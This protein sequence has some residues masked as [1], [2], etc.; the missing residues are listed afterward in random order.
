[1]R[2]DLRRYVA[3]PMLADVMVEQGRK[4]TW[5]AR[6]LHIH[7]SYLSR[8]V[9]GERMVSEL[10]ARSIA[11]H[12]GVPFGLLFI[13]PDG[14]GNTRGRENGDGRSADLATE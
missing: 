1:M 10:R 11:D 13:S 7:R 5:L 4:A 9:A 2:N 8:I 14:A 3:T 6:K 12:L